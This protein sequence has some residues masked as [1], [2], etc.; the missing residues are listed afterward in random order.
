M[1]D[2]YARNR[3]TGQATQPRGM[4]LIVGLILVLALTLIGVTAVRMATMD[5]RI[6]ANNL[7]G[8]VAFQA[9]ESGLAEATEDKTLHQSIFD[10]VRK[11]CAQ[12]EPVGDYQYP[13][14][15][16]KRALTATATVT[17]SEDPVWQSRTLSWEGSSLGVGVADFKVR[18]FKL[19]S[20][21]HGPPNSN[22]KATH[23]L[24]IGRIVPAKAQ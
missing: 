20:E 5:E 2:R 1:K 14:E 21:G 13:V 19:E 6:A 10:C 18:V 4:A 8:A 24:G 15:L 22:G 3:Y 17:L 11:G 12:P 16:G 9:A 7:Y 23:I